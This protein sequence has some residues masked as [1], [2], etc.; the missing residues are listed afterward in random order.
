[1]KMLDSK[2]AKELAIR[3]LEQSHS[4]CDAN[5]VL[6]KKIWNVIVSYGLPN[7]QLKL[8]QIDAQNGKILGCEDH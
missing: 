5:A 4:I 1:M 2:R 8:V 3:F 7:K 6:D